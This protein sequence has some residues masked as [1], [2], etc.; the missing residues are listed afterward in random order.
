M[1]INKIHSRTDFFGITREPHETA[2]DVWTRIL[3]TEKNC[4]FD[5]V[6]L[7]ELIALKFLSLIRRS[8]GDYELK[9]KYGKAR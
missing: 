6:T 7:A 9:I 8:T 5:N 1:G 2:E 4:E 3:Q